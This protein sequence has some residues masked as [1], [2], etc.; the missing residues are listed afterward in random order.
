[1]GSD[2]LPHPFYQSHCLR[3]GV[4]DPPAEQHHFSVPD[5]PACV[6]QEDG[7]HLAVVL[8]VVA[9]QALQREEAGFMRRGDASVG[10][11]LI[12]ACKA[13]ARAGH[14]CHNPSLTGRNATW[15]QCQ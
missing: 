15:P 13:W 8:A 12:E 2:Q 14:Q 1:M 4:A 11:L 3:A 6:S 5:P 10:W 7:C 9:V